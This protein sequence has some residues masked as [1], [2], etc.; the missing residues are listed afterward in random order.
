MLHMFKSLKNILFYI[1]IYIPMIIKAQEVTAPRFGKGLLNISGKD[2]TWS[3]NLSARVQYLTSTT[4]NEEENSYSG[5]KSNSL[6]RRSRIKIKG[7][8][9]HP[10]LTYKVELALSNRDISGGS[11]FTSDTPRIILDASVRWRFYK[12]WS[13]QFGQAK[14]PGNI[15]RVIS[16]SKLALV[17]RSLLNSKFNIDRDFGLQLKHKFNL[18]EKFI[19]K[20]TLAISQGE[21]RNISKGNIGGHQYTGRLDLLPFGNFKSDGDY[22]GDDLRREQ[23]PKL[24]LG[25]A[26]DY[27]NNAVKTRSNMGSYM[28]TD[29]GLF[30]TDITTFFINSH[31]KYKG[32]SFMGEYADRNTKDKYSKN[33]DGSLTGD[34]VN[35]GSA[36]SLQTGYVLP[37]NSAITGRYTNV[38]FDKTVTNNNNISQYTLGLSK[39]FEKHKL[40]IQSDITYENSIFFD[41]KIF[42]RL[43]FEIHF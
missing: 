27:N 34:I 23:A 33:S 1:V 16:S 25:F 17:D 19:I 32:F 6:I 9:Y 14:L 28:E 21:G 24:L 38:N 18:S 36:I 4:W 37:S 15:E 20:E 35:I 11:N 13:I 39:Y 12:N 42:Y 10:T 29:Y 7:F 26:Y 30:E 31:F 2:S 43:Q 5:P 3:M 41:D 22:E 8:A 40:K